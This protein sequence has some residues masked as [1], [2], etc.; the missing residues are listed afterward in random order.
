MVQPEGHPGH[1]DR[2]EGGDVDGEDVVGQLVEGGCWMF[3]DPSKTDL[4]FEHH[5]HRETTV[6]ARGRLHVALNQK[7]IIII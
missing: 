6:K 3:D 4:P 7:I 5:V 2:H 1:A